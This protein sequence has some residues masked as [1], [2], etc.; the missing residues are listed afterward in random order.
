MSQIGAS[1]RPIL[2]R[3]NFFVASELG[4]GDLTYHL[5][6]RLTEPYQN[7]GPFDGE[8]TGDTTHTTSVQQTDSEIIA[9]NKDICA[10]YIADRYG[11]PSFTAGDIRGGDTL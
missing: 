1:G 4:N 2:A 5:G 10:A 6:F 8:L 9:L 7:G 3:A 11:D